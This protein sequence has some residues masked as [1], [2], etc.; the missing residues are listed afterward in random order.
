MIS[1]E[2]TAGQVDNLHISRLPLSPMAWKLAK[3]KLISL[4]RELDAAKELSAMGQ[5]A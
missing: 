3:S 4:F 1:A 2:N 5:E